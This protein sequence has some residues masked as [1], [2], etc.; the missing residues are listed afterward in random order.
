MRSGRALTEKVDSNLGQEFLLADW[1]KG[2]DYAQ[3][4]RT[5]KKPRWSRE[6][7]LSTRSLDQVNL[8]AAF[9]EARRKLIDLGYRVMTSS[10]VFGELPDQVIVIGPIGSI[11]DDFATVATTQNIGAFYRSGQSYTI[12][13]AG[14]DKARGRRR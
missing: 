11:K 8:P 13:H 6:Q 1:F 12:H 3:P 10:H 4:R 14:Y 7:E 5:P 9:A 2:P